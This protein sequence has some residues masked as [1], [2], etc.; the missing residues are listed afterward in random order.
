MCKRHLLNRLQKYNFRT[1]TNFFSRF[2]KTFTQREKGQNDHFFRFFFFPKKSL[3]F[4]FFKNFHSA[5]KRPKWPFFV[6]FQ[7]FHFFFLKFDHHLEHLILFSPWLKVC[8]MF[9]LIQLA[10]FFY[11]I[12]FLITNSNFIILKTYQKPRK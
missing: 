1:Q 5:G 7:K 2:F 11:Q 3:F 4:S 8:I 12:P 10:Y 9:Y 6:F